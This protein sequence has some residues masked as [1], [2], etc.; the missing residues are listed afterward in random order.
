MPDGSTLAEWIRRYALD[1]H[2]G[3]ARQAQER[4]VTIRAGDVHREL[5]LTNC[6]PAVC[7]ALGSALFELLAG[8]ILMERTGPIQSTTTHFRY[9]F[10]PHS[11]DVIAGR[12]PVSTQTLPRSPKPQSMATSRSYSAATVTPETA[13]GRRLFLVSCVKTKLSRLAKAKALY[14]SNWFQKVRVYVE[15]ESGAWRIL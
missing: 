8:V 14:I 9:R 1:Q 6:I 12:I 4:T 13:G 5:D 11:R 7:S 3:P 2:V 10:E 15:R